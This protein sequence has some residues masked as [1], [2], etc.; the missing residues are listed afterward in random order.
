MNTRLK[1]FVV[2]STGRSWMC[3]LEKRRRSAALQNAGAVI[4]DLQARE[5]SWTA[6]ALWRFVRQAITTKIPYALR[7]PKSIE[8]LYEKTIL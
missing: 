6:P 3:S 7:A 5:A 2:I 4:Y 1:T 8:L